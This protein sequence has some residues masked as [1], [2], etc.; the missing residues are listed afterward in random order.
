[1]YATTRIYAPIRPPPPTRKSLPLTCKNYRYR[2]S[3]LTVV[4]PPREDLGRERVRP[5]ESRRMKVLEGSG[6]GWGSG[7]WPF[8]MDLLY[9]EGP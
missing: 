4:I 2:L 8:E 6:C 5:R 7:V 9:C 3:S 1:M